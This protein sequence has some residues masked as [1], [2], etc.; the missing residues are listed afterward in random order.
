M[1]GQGGWPMTVWLTP[2]KEPF[3]AGTYFPKDDRPGMPSFT[4]VL[5]GLHVAWLDNRDDLTAQAARITQAITQRLPVF[6]DVPGAAELE[7]AYRS[8][9]ARAD[10]VHGGIGGAPK[11]PQ[12]P[13]LEFLLRVSDLSFADEA[14]RVAFHALEAMAVGGLYDHIGGGFYRYAVDST[15]TIPHFEKMLYTNAQLARLYLRAWQLGGPDRFRTIAVE[16][17]EYLMRDLAVGDGFGSAEDADSEGL[18]GKFYVFGRRE[19]DEIVGDDAGVAVAFFGVTEHGNFEGKNHLRQAATV[20]ELADQFGTNEDEIIEAIGRARRRLFE[21]RGKRVR[22]GLDDKVI[23]SWNALAIRAF[24]EAGAILDEPRYLDQARQTARFIRNRMI[25]NG[26][27]QRSHAQGRTSGGGF[28]DDHAGLA[29]AL[30][31][32]F[33]ATGELDWY[34]QALHLVDIV[35]NE[36]IDEGELYSTAATAE[37]LITRPKDQMDNPLPSGSSLAAEAFLMRALYQGEPPD[38]YHQVLRE[39]GPLLDRYPTAAAHLLALMASQQKGLIEV[40]VSGSEALT[41]SRPF[42]AA[43]RHHAVL[44]MDVD[45]SGDALIPLLAGRWSSE[46][47]RGF[48]CEG[49]VCDLPA[50]SSEELADQLDR[51]TG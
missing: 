30:F 32:L 19:F 8:I 21:A 23:T 51:A 46:T 14:R 17:L 43:F 50:T 34:E 20:P 5:Q 13:A 48:V 35:E 28:L 15:W 3:Y 16:T 36:F 45:G 7:S 42:W 9:V 25:V 29:V 44:A 6:E 10:E 41:F 18:E 40:A 37:P 2:D 4:R 1:T 24:A 26:T 11:F 33:Q 22:P 27:L 31:T 38:G 49:F 12:E 47:T 39:A